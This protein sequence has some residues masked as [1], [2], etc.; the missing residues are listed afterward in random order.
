[1]SIYLYQLQ[2]E[3]DKTY[4]IHKDLRYSLQNHEALDLCST[5]KYLD[6]KIDLY[7]ITSSIVV[8]NITSHS[9][10]F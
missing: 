3:H 2:S 1:M 4:L 6:T 7:A 8:V 10:V 5:N 9:A